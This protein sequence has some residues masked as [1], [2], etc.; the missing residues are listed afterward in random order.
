MTV[1]L[2]LPAELGSSLQAKAAKS[3]LSLSQYLVAMA[4]QD[5]AADVSSR[6]YSTAEVDAILQQDQLPP[7]LAHKVQRLLGDDASLSGRG[8]LGGGGRL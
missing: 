1:T 6:D 5:A 2:E 8:L 3:G 4:Q 7:E